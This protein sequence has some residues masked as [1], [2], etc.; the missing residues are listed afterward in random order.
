MG[1]SDITY[2]EP[3][4]VYCSGCCDMADIAETS[5]ICLECYSRARSPSIAEL[6]A[7]LTAE[8][9]ALEAE[10]A[11]AKDRITIWRTNAD[12]FSKSARRGRIQGRAVR[13][14]AEAIA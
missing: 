8:R 12:V 1:N 10:L 14:G 6:I 11:T 4:M 5:V 13:E 7:E 2:R 3:T 9:D